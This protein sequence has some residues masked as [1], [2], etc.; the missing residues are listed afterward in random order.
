MIISLIVALISLAVALLVLR[1]ILQPRAN[2]LRAA[3]QAFRFHAIRD[4]VQLLAVQGKVDQSD[5]CYQFVMQ[6]ANLCIRNAGVMKLRDTLAIAQTVTEE[7]RCQ[8]LAF[9][10]H[11][12]GQP[13]PM[14]RV[15]GETFSALSDMLLANDRLVRVAFKIAILVATTL[16]WVRPIFRVVT[17]AFTRVAPTHAQSV[18]YAREFHVL[19]DRLAAAG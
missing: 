16:K 19:G 9:L 11:V 1:L 14:Q 6:T 4:E 2:R 17:A 8:A 3:Q 15:V 13:E 7:M 10:K 18:R 5:P 12:R